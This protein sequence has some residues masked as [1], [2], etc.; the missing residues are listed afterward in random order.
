[1][2]GAMDRM[3]K[4]RRSAVPVADSEATAAQMEQDFETAL[5]Q[6]GQ[7]GASQLL[8]GPSFPGEASPGTLEQ[9]CG[10][11]PGGEQHLPVASPFHSER[12]KEEV[13]LQRH[14]PATLDS[15]Q[16][17][18]QAEVR[19]CEQEVEPDYGT[20]L[21]GLDGRNPRV[22]RI[23]PRPETL[24]DFWSGVTVWDAESNEFAGRGGGEQQPQ[25]HASSGFGGKATRGAGR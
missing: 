20:A 14:R 9:G 18:L 22:A 17:R 5:G 16:E 2:T 24:E 10:A 6:T 11:G 8:V 7:R 25:G 3:V 15:D 12:V 4:N 13:A 1:M 23:E 21:D 19:V